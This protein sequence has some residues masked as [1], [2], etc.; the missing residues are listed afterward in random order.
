MHF[1]SEALRLPI[2]MLDE[3]QIAGAY[4]AAIIAREEH[5]G[6]VALAA[7]TSLRQ[8]ELA[9]GLADAVPA[10]RR[11]RWPARGHIHHGPVPVTIATRPDGRRAIGRSRTLN[12]RTL[13]VLAGDSSILGWMPW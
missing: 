4:G 9:A 1:L 6:N 7:R 3:P 13:S 11:L 12:R 2:E 8:Q 10:L 5:L